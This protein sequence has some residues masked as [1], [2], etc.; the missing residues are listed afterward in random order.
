M[1]S[2]K[3]VTV[4]TTAGWTDGNGRDSTAS[5]SVLRSPCRS[6]VVINRAAPKETQAI[7]GSVADD[8]VNGT[9]P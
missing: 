4:L 8:A 6:E 5:L 9:L 7:S 1:A 3:A 2:G